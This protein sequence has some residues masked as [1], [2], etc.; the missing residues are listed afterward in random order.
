VTR[1]VGATFLLGWLV[2]PIAHAGDLPEVAVVG[3]HVDGLDAD[4]G[5]RLSQELVD[6]LELSGRLDALD[7]AEVAQRLS[8]REDLVVEDMAMR[9]GVDLLRSGR[10]LYERAQPDQAIPELQRATRALGH[11][12]LITGQ[13]REL[14]ESWLLLGLAEFGMGNLDA[15]HSAWRQVAILA[16]SRELDPLNYPPKVIEQFNTVRGDVRA[17]DQG[18]LQVTAGD[19]GAEVFVDGRSVGVAPL[20]IEGLSPGQH[21]VYAQDVAGH[22]AGRRVSL[23]PGAGVSVDFS[24]E[25]YQLGIASSKTAG[26]A[27]QTQELYESLGEHTQ[28]DLVLL[29]GLSGEGFV[30]VQLYS[31]RAGN[32]S[33]TITAEALDEPVQAI[34]DLVP[35]VAG[36]ATESGDIRTDRV[37]LEVPAFDVTSNAVLTRVLLEHGVALPPSPPPSEPGSAMGG[38]AK[39][40]AVGGAAIVVGGVAGGIALLSLT[41]DGGTDTDDNNGTVVMSID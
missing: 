35:A 36:Y 19:S 27:R 38:N 11:G 26:R 13:T 20:T 6:A 41:Q 4:R 30:S 18:T 16:P 7:P 25:A 24:M 29:A 21:F 15:A 12:A 10:L 1:I 5:A 23:E 34:L 37:A 2:A 32:F 3:V 33:R 40:I 9:A 14:I 39:W 8:G 28:T 22:R 17:L 31:P